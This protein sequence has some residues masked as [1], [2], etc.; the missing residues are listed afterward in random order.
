MGG[1]RRMKEIQTIN[2]ETLLPLDSR[3]FS[4]LSY[5]QSIERVRVLFNEFNTTRTIN[6]EIVESFLSH[7]KSS[8]KPTSYNTYKSN[9]LQLLKT[10]P[11]LKHTENLERVE[12][13]FR[14]STV[15][16]YT[17]KTEK[18]FTEKELEIIYSQTKKTHSLFLRF[19]YDSAC[20]VSEMLDSEIKNCKVIGKIVIVTVIGK[21]RKE[22]HLRIPKELYREILET[23]KGKRYLFEHSGRKYTRQYVYNFLKKYQTEKGVSYSPHNFRHSRATHC[24]RDGW[25][26]QQLKTLTGHSSIKTLIQSYDKNT[27]DEDLFLKKAI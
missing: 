24:I 16:T 22:R 7:L 8:Y 20:R 26:F 2:S 4:S 6:I 15:K 12:K 17:D 18:T 21:G 11:V 25:S 19:M 13:L 3:E 23:F 10:L 14:K 1:D 5:Y 27:F 9:F